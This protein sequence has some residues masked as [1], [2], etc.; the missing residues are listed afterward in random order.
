M[1]VS[2]RLFSWVWLNYVQP[3][4]F[5]TAIAIKTLL[6]GRIKPLS[7]T[8]T[9]IL[10]LM[11]VSRGNKWSKQ[12]IILMW[13]FTSS[14]RITSNLVQDSVFTTLNHQSMQSTSIFCKTDHIFT[15]YP[16]LMDPHDV[17]WT[18]L[19]D[20]RHSLHWTRRTCLQNWGWST[21]THQTLDSWKQNTCFLPWWRSG[22]AWGST[23]YRVTSAE[24]RLGP[25][26]NLSGLW[27]ISSRSQAHS[28]FRRKVRCHRTSAS[29]IPVTFRQHRTL[30]TLS[31]P[32]LKRELDTPHYS[33]FQTA[34]YCECQTEDGTVH[35]FQDLR[36]TMN[37]LGQPENE[38]SLVIA[39]CGGRFDFQF[40]FH[41]FF[42]SGE[43]VDH[44]WVKKVKLPL[45]RG[46][47]IIW[48]TWW[49]VL[50]KI[51]QININSILVSMIVS[52][53]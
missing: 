22:K 33:Y 8:H 1:C 21:W 48:K 18:L 32:F 4:Q 40:L 11:N 9:S 2:P 46:N 26:N 42:D 7:F 20:I 14:I 49:I 36:Q 47:K 44:V 12:P 13:T 43:G 39:H 24:R 37:W 28:T 41:N 34:N 29:P 45:L 10:E 51:S 31:D 52:V 3:E 19:Q 25:K 53:V 50:L 16:T 6:Y 27:D 35:V 15:S 38:G 30:S 5:T 23:L 17:L